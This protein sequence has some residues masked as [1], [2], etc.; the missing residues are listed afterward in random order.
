MM[1]N[2]FIF[3]VLV[4]LCSSKETVGDLPDSNVPKRYTITHEAVF[5]IV[6]KENVHTDEVL[7]HGRIV[8]GLFG[9]IVPMTVLNFVTITNGIVRSNV[10]RRSMFLINV[11]FILI[12]DKF[13]I[14]RCPLSSYCKR[15]LYSNR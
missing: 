6:I 1:I 5:D 10:R 11:Y 13:Y 3:I 15:F 2:Y 9:E 14:Q 7:S 4:A 8:I 12:L